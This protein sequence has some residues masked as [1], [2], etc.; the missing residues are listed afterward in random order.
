MPTNGTIPALFK[1][2]LL[3]SQSKS[4]IPLGTQN[5]NIFR[6]FSCIPEPDKD[7]GMWYVVN[8]ALDSCF[9]VEN[10]EENLRSGKYGIEVVLDYLKAARVDPTWK[11][12][13]L[14]ALKLDRIYKCFEDAG[15]VVAEERP[16]ILSPKES[17]KNG[18]LV[19]VASNASQA[20]SGLSKSTAFTPS[21]TSNSMIVSS[22]LPRKTEKPTLSNRNPTVISNRK[23]LNFYFCAPKDASDASSA[24]PGL[25]KLTASA[26][27]KTLSSPIDK[28]SV[29][30]LISK[31]TFSNPKPIAS[32][33]TLSRRKIDNKILLKCPKSKKE[34]VCDSCSITKHDDS[35]TPQDL[36]FKCHCGAPAVVLPQG[37]MQSVEIHW[38]S[39]SC[40]LITSSVSNTRQLTTYFPRKQPLDCQNTKSDPLESEPEPKKKT[41]Q[42]LCSGLNDNNWPRKRGKLTILQCIKGSPSSH[43]GAP[44]CHIVCRELF[45]TTKES[46]LTESQFQQ[47]L[48]TLELKST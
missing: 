7:E 42:V 8:Q 4:K 9:G 21:D 16:E 33:S 22:S 3:I 6:L 34:K 14:L 11:E 45:N 10:C 28:R 18:S 37:R 2:I 39:R 15:G 48:R 38:Q 35:D 20:K 47:L 32:V 44:P 26:S 46:E 17:Q 41:I 43:H 24:K 12:D 29:P 25:S 30:E 27:K 5:D 36:L 31:S 19:K 23:D 40:K 13:E 1:K